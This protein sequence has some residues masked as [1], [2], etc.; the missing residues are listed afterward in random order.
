MFESMGVEAFAQ[1][2][3]PESVA[4]EAPGRTRRVETVYD[5]TARELRIARPAADGLTSR[6][7]ASQFF[8]SPQTVQYRLTKVF[9]KLG[10]RSRIQLAKAIPAEAL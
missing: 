1:Q 10:V 6:E 7:I 5:P 3:R 2:S 4:T 8:I 9:H